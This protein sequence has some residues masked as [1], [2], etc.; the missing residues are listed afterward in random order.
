MKLQTLSLQDDRDKGK[1]FTNSVS[2]ELQ[3]LKTDVESIKGLLLSK[4]QFP[5][6]S[7]SIPSWQ[8]KA[9]EHDLEHKNEDQG[10]NSSETEVVTKHSDSKSDSSLEMM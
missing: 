9:S 3:N 10:S 5:T 1:T 2:R 4:N 8:L 7:S 6:T